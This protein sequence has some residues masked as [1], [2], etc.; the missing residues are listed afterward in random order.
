MILK[1][2]QD[3]PQWEHLVIHQRQQQKVGQLRS[4]VI[5]TQGHTHTR[6]LVHRVIVNHDYKHT[7]SYTHKAKSRNLALETFRHEI[8]PRS[9]NF[10]CFRHNILPQSFDFSCCRPAK[11]GFLTFRLRPF[12]PKTRHTTWQKSATI[13]FCSITVH[14]VMQKLTWKFVCP[15]RL[16]VQFKISKA[17]PS[18]Q[19]KYCVVCIN[20][21]KE[22]SKIYISHFTSVYKYFH[23]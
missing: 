1:A 7:R 18:L 5:G 3:I 16:A 21:V 2:S 4:K 17:L 8:L 11:L 12:A 20:I 9:F 19:F 23:D 13:L 6:S 10:S 15:N 14:T 22:E